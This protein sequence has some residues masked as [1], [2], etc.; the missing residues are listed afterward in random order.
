MSETYEC[1]C[2]QRISLQIA[3]DDHCVTADAGVLGAEIDWPC[4]AC[5]AICSMRIFVGYRLITGPSLEVKY[6]KA[7]ADTTE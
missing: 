2:G 1:K 7:P 3:S 6:W 4:P 5:K